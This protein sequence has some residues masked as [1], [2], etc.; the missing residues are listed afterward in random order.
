MSWSIPQ[1]LSAFYSE[2]GHDNLM[3]V[4]SVNSGTPL[5]TAPSVNQCA[6]HQLHSWDWA[7]TP[8]AFTTWTDFV[9]PHNACTTGGASCRYRVVDPAAVG[10]TFTVTAT[11]Q[12]RTKLN[13]RTVAG[14]PVTTEVRVGHVW[15]S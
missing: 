13:G 15:L 11:P 1:P 12:G 9:A 8:P 7:F 2:T 10:N 4:I 6:N 3:Y 5:D 14:T